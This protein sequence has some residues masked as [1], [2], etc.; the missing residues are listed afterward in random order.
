M[1]AIN[2]PHIHTYTHI[3]TFLVKYTKHIYTNIAYKR[4]IIYFQGKKNHNRNREI[5]R[6]KKALLL[7]ALDS[8]IFEETVLNS[9]K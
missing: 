4:K 8:C 6:Q 9:I 2:G 3:P 1:R 5:V 7:S